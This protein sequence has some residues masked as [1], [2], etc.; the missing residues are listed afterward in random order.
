MT[1]LL[2]ELFRESGFEKRNKEEVAKKEKTQ[3]QGITKAILWW[4]WSFFCFVLFFPKPLTQDE[5]VGCK[6]CIC[7]LGKK[8]IRG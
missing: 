6:S 1:L 4:S 5:N 8:S 7:G 2:R 3:V